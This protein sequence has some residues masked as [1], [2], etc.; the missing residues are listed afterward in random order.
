MRITY[1]PEVD[2]AYIYLTDVELEP[3]IDTI[4][5]EAPDGSAMVNMDWKDGK[6]VGLEVLDASI[7]L[8][9][10]LLAQATSPGRS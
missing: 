2:A 1:D 6:I 7:L 3:G 10:D 4:P 8:H 9:P 5:L